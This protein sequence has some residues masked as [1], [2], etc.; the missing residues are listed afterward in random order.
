[1]PGQ[2]RPYGRDR[3]PGCREESLNVQGIGQVGQDTVR[4]PMPQAMPHPGKPPTG[5]GAAP[6]QPGGRRLQSCC[7]A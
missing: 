3:L 1:M 5:L 4:P 6:I 7:A 2:I